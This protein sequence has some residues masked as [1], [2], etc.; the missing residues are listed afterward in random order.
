V[1]VPRVNETTCLGA[2]YAA[3]LAAGYWSNLQDLRANHQIA[4]SWQPA[5]SAD[6]RQALYA[7]WQQAVEKSFG[8]V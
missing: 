3:G 8:W 6:C 5:M 4:Q 7:R 1:Q 2:A